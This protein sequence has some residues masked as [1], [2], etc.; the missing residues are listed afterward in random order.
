M[1]ESEILRELLEVTKAVRVEPTAEE[2]AEM[3]ILEEQ[4]KRSEIDRQRMDAQN[5]KIKRE[6]AFLA[7]ARD[8]VEAQRAAAAL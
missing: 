4:R 5:R 1:P 8:G 7:V 6:K 3:E 2:K